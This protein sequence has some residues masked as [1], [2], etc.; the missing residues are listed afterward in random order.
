MDLGG[1]DDDE[2]EAEEEEKKTEQKVEE[3][4]ELAP[5]PAPAQTPEAVEPEGK[6]RKDRIV[7]VEEKKTI[8]LQRKTVVI[9]KE[10]EPVKMDVEEG[11]VRWYNLFNLNCFCFDCCFNLALR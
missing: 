1:D 4:T 10:H 7:K 6:R 2:K 8:K 11:T 9:E 3:E 5:A